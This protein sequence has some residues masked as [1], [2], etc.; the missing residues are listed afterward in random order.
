[1][2]SAGASLRGRISAPDAIWSP[3]R[4]SQQLPDG[5]LQRARRLTEA[6]RLRGV[7][8]DRDIAPVDVSATAPVHGAD[9]LRVM[10]ARSSWTASGWTPTVAMRPG[11]RP[12]RD[13]TTRRQVRECIA[14]LPGDPCCDRVSRRGRPRAEGSPGPRLGDPMTDPRLWNGR[15]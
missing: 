9:D 13:S 14:K 4:S 3:R 2:P 5:S 8:P 6:A 1:M 7:A 11:R 12:I 10:I 15:R